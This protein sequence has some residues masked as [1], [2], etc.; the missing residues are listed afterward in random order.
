MKSMWPPLAMTYLYRAGGGHGPLGPP[1][2]LLMLH[3]SFF[4]YMLWLIYIAGDELGDGLGLG[5]L[6]YTEI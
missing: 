5:F 2:P 6:S 4:P 1:D 3:M